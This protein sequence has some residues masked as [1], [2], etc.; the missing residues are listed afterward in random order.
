MALEVITEYLGMVIKGTA[1]VLYSLRLILRLEETVT[2]WHGGWD[3]A[4][5]ANHSFVEEWVRV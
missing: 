1:A 4:F 3:T 5:R 2:T